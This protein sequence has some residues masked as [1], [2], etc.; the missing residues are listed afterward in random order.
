MSVTVNIKTI[1]LYYLFFTN[2]NSTTKSILCDKK[3]IVL[4]CLESTRC[5]FR[6]DAVVRGILEMFLWIFYVMNIYLFIHS[7]WKFPQLKIL[8]W[9][10][11]QYFLA[12]GQQRFNDSHN[13]KNLYIWKQDKN[14]LLR[15]N[16]EFL[17][18]TYKLWLILW[19]WDISTCVYYFISNYF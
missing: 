1:F 7:M 13:N 19:S 18:N 12:K 3:Q 5:H 14:L 2:F 11:L 9:H 10:L 15:W 16:I 17:K 8:L 4:V 6:W